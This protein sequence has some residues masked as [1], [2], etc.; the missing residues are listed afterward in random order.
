[1][2]VKII[3]YNMGMGVSDRTSKKQLIPTKDAAFNV[4]AKEFVAAYE[5]DP[6]AAWFVCVQEILRNSN[7]K[8]VNQVEELQDRLNANT[9]A[10][11]YKNSTTI[12]DSDQKEAVAIFSTIERDKEQKWYLKDAGGGNRVA[13]AYKAKLAS[14]KYIWVV[15]THLIAPEK[16]PTGEMREA[17]INM[18]LQNIA[19]FDGTVPVVLCGDMNV[20]DPT[21]GTYNGVDPE[22][23][24]FDQT[25]RKVARFGFTRGA[26]FTPDKSFITFHA[27]SDTSSTSGTWGILDYIQVNETGKCTAQA[28]TI[29][30]YQSDDL[31]ASDHKGL[32]MEIDF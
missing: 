24:V 11:W 1:M 14:G 12:P 3:T 17:S 28:P 18:I 13:Q 20:F 21:S 26:G 5:S 6:T 10:S 19:S 4:F 23:D 29:I 32:E 27:W 7:E 30:N 16:D 22:P 15:T 25:I 31:F 2:K 9:T 8:I